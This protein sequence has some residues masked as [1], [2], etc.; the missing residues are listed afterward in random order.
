MGTYVNVF[1][2]ELILV[3]GGFGVAAWKYL[4]P[5]AEEAMRRESLVPARDQV[6]VAP[7]ELGPAAG[8]V[9]AAFVAFEALDGAL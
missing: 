8:L 1:N 9:G 3:G 4:I 7:A 2:P 5:A 6:R